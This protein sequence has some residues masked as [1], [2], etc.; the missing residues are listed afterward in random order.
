[1]DQLV[2]QEF[3]WL[4]VMNVSLGIATLLVMLFAIGAMARDIAHHARFHRH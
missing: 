4:H 1:M 3:T 2:S